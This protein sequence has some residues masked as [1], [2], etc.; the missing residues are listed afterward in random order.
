M[1][2]SPRSPLLAI[3]CLNER[4]ADF[5]SN[6]PIWLI[7]LLQDI[8]LTNLYQD[9]S[10]ITEWKNPTSLLKY[11]TAIIEVKLTILS[12]NTKKT[13]QQ[14]S[15]LTAIFKCDQTKQCAADEGDQTTT[16]PSQNKL[17]TVVTIEYNKP[18]GPA[19]SVTELIAAAVKTQTASKVIATQTLSAYLSLTQSVPKSTTPSLGSTIASATNNF[20]GS[21]TILVSFPELAKIPQKIALTY[22]LPNPNSKMAFSLSP[23]RAAIVK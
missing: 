7:W 16:H 12:K 6:D 3:R 5:Q 20:G 10:Q 17:E 2:G 21:G 13:E 15:E 9:T 22:K 11:L 4:K 14:A 18:R 23:T 19:N 1:F 8:R